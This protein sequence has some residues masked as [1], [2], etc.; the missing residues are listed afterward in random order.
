MA[1]NLSS[2]KE[3]NRIW[4]LFNYFLHRSDSKWL[5]VVFPGVIIITKTQQVE[6]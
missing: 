1:L 5:I 6:A 4:F 2:I 3:E